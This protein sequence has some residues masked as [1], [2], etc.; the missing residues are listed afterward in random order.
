MGVKDGRCVELKKKKKKKKMMM[1]MMITGR[2]AF[3][4]ECS[5]ETDRFCFP[6]GRQA[7]HVSEG[8]VKQDVVT[9]GG[10]KGFFYA[11][12]LGARF[13]GPSR[14]LFDGYWGKAVGA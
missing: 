13:W 11:P 6:C 5:V 14:H 1:M 7:A 9:P 4:F 2:R 8:K 3:T 10:G 12:E